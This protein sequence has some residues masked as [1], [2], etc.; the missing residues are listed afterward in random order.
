MRVNTI[1]KIR[2][3]ANRPVYTLT[4]RVGGTSLIFF[5]CLGGGGG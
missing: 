2:K 3:D 4:T 1:Q 5:F